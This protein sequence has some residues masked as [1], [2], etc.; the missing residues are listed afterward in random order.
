LFPKASHRPGL[1]LLGA[2][3]LAICRLLATAPPPPADLLLG[4]GVIRGPGLAPHSQCDGCFGRAA[5]QDNLGHLL[6]H[7]VTTVRTVTVMLVSLSFFSR[8][9]SSQLVKHLSV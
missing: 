8:Y 1:G 3:R 5:H 6:F 2:S 9:V 4:L 7:S